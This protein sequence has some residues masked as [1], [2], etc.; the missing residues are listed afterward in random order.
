[1]NLYNYR[2]DSGSLKDRTHNLDS[3]GS[4][5][6]RK[7]VFL[8]ASADDNA[9]SFFLRNSSKLRERESTNC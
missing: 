4:V 2:G 8:T 5:R 6:I 9:L 1:M 3:I 7:A